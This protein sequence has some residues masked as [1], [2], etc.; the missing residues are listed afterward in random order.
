MYENVQNILGVPGHRV[1]KKL[2]FEGSSTRVGADT[3]PPSAKK[4][5]EGK[6]FQEFINAS[7]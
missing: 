1:R 2:H 5:L 6:W 3:I 7:V 4:H